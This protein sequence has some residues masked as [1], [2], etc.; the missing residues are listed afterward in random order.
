MD[1][2]FQHWFDTDYMALY[3][4]RDE[5]EAE[6]AVATVL[7][8]APALGRGPVLDLA[9]GSGRH[10]AVLRQHNPE[11][12]GLDLSRELLAQAP[13]ELRPHLL[14]GDMRHL[15]LR[16]SSLS[17]L[18][19]WFT[20]FGYFGEAENRQLLK[21]LAI[22]LR[23]GGV[24]VMDYL[25]AQLVRNGLIE[26]DTQEREGLRVTSRRSLEGTRLV[27]RMRLE[28]LDAGSVREVVESV[29]LYDPAELEGMLLAAGLRVNTVLGDYAGGTFREDHSPRWLALAEREKA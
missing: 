17:G 16:P 20:P 23:P 21:A 4:H 19:L 15:P 29:R 3:A 7:R 24:L 12:F 18:T 27:K 11:A 26:E 25:N 9:C 8:A 1:D 2:W 22:L 13:Q 6:L 14:R 5:A 10:L 28:R